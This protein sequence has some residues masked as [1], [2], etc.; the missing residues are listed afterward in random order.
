MS[1]ITYIRITTRTGEI[2]GGNYKNLVKRPEYSPLTP[3]KLRLIKCLPDI[4]RDGMKIINSPIQIPMA[5]LEAALGKIIPYTRVFC[6]NY[7]AKNPPKHFGEMIELF[8]QHLMLP[9]ALVGVFLDSAV[10]PG[11]KSWQGAPIQLNFFKLIE[12]KTMDL[13]K[14]IVYV[15]LDNMFLLEKWTKGNR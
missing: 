8:A 11:G 3:E 1:A 12:G 5:P 6:T 13:S 4:V 7:P 15:N 14:G 10:D 2:I 9:N